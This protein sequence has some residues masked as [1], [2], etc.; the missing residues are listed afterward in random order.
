LPNIEKEHVGQA[1]WH[2]KTGQLIIL[3]IQIV[4]LDQVCGESETG[5]IIGAETKKAQSP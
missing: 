1:R 3:K 2:A 4:Q 5:K